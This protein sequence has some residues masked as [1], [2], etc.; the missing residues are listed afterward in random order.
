MRSWWLAL[1]PAVVLAAS[2]PCESTPKA[3]RILWRIV[4]E[5]PYATNLKSLLKVIKSDQANSGVVLYKV[6][7]AKT[8][9]LCTTVPYALDVIAESPEVCSIHEVETPA[10]YELKGGEFV[11]K[12]GQP[13]PYLCRCPKHGIVGVTEWQY[14]DFLASGPV[15]MLTAAIAHEMAPKANSEPKHQHFTIKCPVCGRPS[16]ALGAK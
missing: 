1:I 10:V 14:A 8:V 6:E 5:K 15:Q 7:S 13:T 11:R 9:L 16:E 12:D 3:E 2:L 4:L